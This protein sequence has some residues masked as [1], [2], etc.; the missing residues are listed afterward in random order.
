MVIVKFC[1]GGRAIAAAGLHRDRAAAPCVS[2]SMAAAVVTTPVLT[3]IWNSPSGIAGQAVGDRIVGRIQIKGV[4]R[5]ADGGSH[6]HI[7][8]DGIGGRIAIGRR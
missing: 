8:V 1:A 5:Q 2:R 6:G 3:S 4:G 7:L